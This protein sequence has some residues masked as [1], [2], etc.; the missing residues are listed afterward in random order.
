VTHH[1]QMRHVV[2]RIA[3]KA[4]DVLVRI[5]KFSE[6]PAQG[7]DVITV[8]YYHRGLIVLNHLL[9]YVVTCMRTSAGALF[10]IIQGRWLGNSEPT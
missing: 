9:N 10:I 3:G 7:H 1:W 2:S 6:L 8:V 5:T 4:M